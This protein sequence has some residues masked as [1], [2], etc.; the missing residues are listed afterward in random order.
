VKKPFAFFV[1]F[2]LLGSLLAA[3]GETSPTAPAAQ[4]GTSQSAT[5]ATG[6]LVIGALEEPANMSP[7]SALPHHFP[8]HIAQTLMF[9]SL[10]QFMPDGSLTPKL[11]ASYEVSNDKLSYTFKLDSR[12]K[13][14]DGTPV[15]ADDVV[16]TI[17]TL[18]DPASKSSTEGVTDV[19]GIEAVDPATV[20]VTIKAFN[21]VF[22]PQFASRGIVPKAVLQGKDVANDEFNKKPLGSGPYK[23][24]KWE[25]GQFLQLEANPN[26][27]LG[28][29]KIG[30]VTVK[31][32]AEQ[33][34]VLQ[35]FRSGAL[36]YALLQ[37]RDLGTVQPATLA[38]NPSPRFY[39]ISPN[40]KRILG[41]L[42]LREAVLYGTNRESIVQNILKGKGSV[43]EANV[44]PT[45]WNWAYTNETVKRSYDAEK[46][47]SLLE[48]AGW[49]PGANGIR[50]KD[51]KPLT[52]GVMVNNYDFILQQVLQAQQSDLKKV[53]FDMKIEVVD[54]GKFGER[55][56]AGDFDAL[57]RVWNPVYDPDQRGLVLSTVYGDDGKVKSGNFY[58]YQNP[59]MDELANAALKTDDKTARAKIYA[60]IQ[61]LYAQ[62][63]VR[64]PLF[65]EVELHAFNLKVEGVKRHPVNV[66]WNIREWTLVK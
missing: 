38:E 66:F 26:Y 53:G 8:E 4:S 27:F 20:K 25:K 19:A 6:T 17:K 46:A 43:I 2:L 48:T 13:W 28:V 37:P 58:G 65:T 3:C 50:E 12:A 10:L 1:V 42:A 29:P 30:K 14:W 5:M 41:D 44:S 24:V 23:F 57:A 51:G 54:P 40:Y 7:L 31:F 47:K 15:T 64:L 39:D 45:G 21:P 56:S 62:D 61:K 18:L 34:T 32:M 55:R 60:D 36:N 22:L 52:F 59:K 11:A 63:A 9:D 49:K 16:F 35:E 33:N